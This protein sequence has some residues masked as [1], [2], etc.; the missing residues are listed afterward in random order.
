MCTWFDPLLE[1]SFNQQSDVRPSDGTGELKFPKFDAYF[2]SADAYSTPLNHV[3]PARI[4]PPDAP[5][6]DVVTM[7]FCMHYAFETEEKVRTML[8]N[9]T[10]WLRR[11]GVFVGT[12]P[13][14]GWLLLV[15]FAF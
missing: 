12:I 15:A 1:S 5:E 2:T 14:S 8:G 10:Q 7:Q 3:L 4:L 11:G 13:N 9:V 6:F